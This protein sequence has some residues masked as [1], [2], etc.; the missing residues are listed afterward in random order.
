M[1]PATKEAKRAMSFN[2]VALL[3]HYQPAV[4]RTKA[5]Q[6]SPDILTSQAAGKPETDAWAPQ[7]NPKDTSSIASPPAS[8]KRQ[9]HNLTSPHLAWTHKIKTCSFYGT[10]VLNKT[11][12]HITFLRSNV[13]DIT[14]TFLM[15]KSPYLR[16][17]PSTPKSS[18]KARLLPLSK[19]FALL[20][21]KRCDSSFHYAAGQHFIVSSRFRPINITHACVLISALARS[22][23]L[24]QCHHKRLRT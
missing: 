20:V 4:R 11:V 24:I 5:S 16:Y 21:L 8:Q 15:S 17:V 10:H 7:K 23:Q 9:N 19:Q 3:G 2:T 18:M 14:A 1:A 22:K 13:I 6:V 12:K